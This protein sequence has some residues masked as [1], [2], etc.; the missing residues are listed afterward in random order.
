MFTCRY[1]NQANELGR[2]NFVNFTY[3]LWYV[4]NIFYGGFLC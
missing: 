1:A 2:E 4:K 3:A